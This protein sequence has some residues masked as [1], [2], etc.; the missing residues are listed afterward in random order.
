MTTSIVENFQNKDGTITV[1]E[2]PYVGMEVFGRYT[3][4]REKK[5]R[6]S[7]SYMFFIYVVTYVIKYHKIYILSSIN[8][9]YE[10]R[11]TLECL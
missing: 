11:R 10:G 5:T 7:L 4:A 1:P 3:G 6:M 8:Y 9:L 2:A